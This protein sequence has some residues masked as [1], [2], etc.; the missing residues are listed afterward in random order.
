MCVKFPGLQAHKCSVPQAIGVLNLFRPQMEWLVKVRCSRIGL[1]RVELVGSLA[2]AHAVQPTRAAE[3]YE[4]V[5]AGNGSAGSPARMLHGALVED[6]IGLANWSLRSNADERKRSAGIV[7]AL[8]QAHIE[9]EKLKAL[10]IERGPAALAW[11]A[12]KLREK[13][14]AV[15]ALFPM[16]RE[17]PA[18]KREAA[19]K[20]KAPAEPRHTRTWTDVP[21]SGAQRAEAAE[22]APAPS[23]AEFARGG[24]NGKRL[25]A[26]AS[27]LLKAAGGRR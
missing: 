9:G 5:I 17:E 12:G 1:R 6:V 13:V 16:V 20:V 3:F 14:L 7:L 21:S 26:A 8:L 2:L 23:P 4:E 27:G 15:A 25:T 10:P 24:G 18:A 11:Y 19:P 22:E